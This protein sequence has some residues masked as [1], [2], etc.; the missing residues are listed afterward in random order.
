MK[1]SSVCM[2]TGVS[3]ATVWVETLCGVAV[4]TQAE[5]PRCLLSD[6]GYC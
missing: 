2:G 5:E 4:R 3:L 1:V 6:P